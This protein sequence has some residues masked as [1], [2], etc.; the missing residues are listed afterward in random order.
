MLDA[1]TPGPAKNKGKAP[2]SLLKRAG[3]YDDERRERVAKQ[4]EEFEK[5]QK[6]E[7]SLVPSGY[8]GLLADGKVFCVSDYCVDLA[9]ALSTR[10]IL[11][12]DKDT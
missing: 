1:K 3:T 5:K 12:Q 8:Y 6:Y 9:E 11:V 10:V 7:I 4:Q 2:K